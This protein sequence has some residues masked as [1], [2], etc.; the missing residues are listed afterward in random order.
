[1]S[2]NEGPKI[3]PLK[4]MGNFKQQTSRFAGRR[5]LRRESTVCFQKATSLMSH[6]LFTIYS[7]SQV[8]QTFLLI[9]Q[10]FIPPVI[11]LHCG[12]PRKTNVTLED[13]GVQ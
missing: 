4:V 2:Q 7:G 5:I 8:V 11:L 3:N 12:P 13:P 9:N 6:V 10:N 1:M